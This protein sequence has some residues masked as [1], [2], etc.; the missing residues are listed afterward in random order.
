MSELLLETSPE[1]LTHTPSEEYLD[2][3]GAE[4]DIP[5]V[6]KIGEA[7]NS[8]ETF[9][10]VG[11]GGSG[12]TESMATAFELQDK[13]YD[14]F[15]LRKWTVSQLSDE[16]FRIASL[17]D[18]E[19]NG[20]ARDFLVQL[21][22]IL[23]LHAAVGEKDGESV[24]DIIKELYMTDQTYGIKFAEA[25]MLDRAIQQLQGS[26]ENSDGLSDELLTIMSSENEIL[27]LDEFDLSIGDSLAPVEIETAAKLIQLAK[28]KSAQLG[29][30]VH[31]AARK[32][33]AFMS[34]VGETLAESGKIHEIDMGYF[35]ESVESAVLSQIGLDGEKAVQFMQ[36]VQGIP[37]A[38]LD[39]CIKP[40]LRSQLLSQDPEQRYHTLLELVEAKIA[41][42]K[43]I[44]FDR[45]TPEAQEYLMEKVNG[46]ESSTTSKE[47]INEALISLYVSEKDGRIFMPPIVK[48]VLS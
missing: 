6:Q 1:S 13:G 23:S 39:I 44:I 18:P 36:E 24:E 42:N 15:D 17:E 14:F 46:S 12:K 9:M 8:N 27:V 21:H 40:E 20:Q 10:V 16:Q 4:L 32:D 34:T 43:P 7:L 47:I 31:P 2:I 22:E 45:M 28:Q 26:A 38:Y 3:G 37:T 48:R 11:G 41:K 25:Y 19:L 33:P 29:L 5:A 35:P 30:V